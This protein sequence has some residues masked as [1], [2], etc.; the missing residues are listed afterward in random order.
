MSIQL[1]DYTKKLSCNFRFSTWPTSS[2]SLRTP[3]EPAAGFWK[4]RWTEKTSTHGNTSPTTA[5]TV[6][7][8]LELR[9]LEQTTGSQSTTR[10]AA[11]LTFLKFRHSR[12]EKSSFR[13]SRVALAPSTSGRVPL[14]RLGRKRE[15]FGFDLNLQKHCSAI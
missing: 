12:T 7:P 2:S 1:Y 13:S 9:T 14:S 15:R 11:L 4:D 8:T 10:S 5:A 3:L 6:H